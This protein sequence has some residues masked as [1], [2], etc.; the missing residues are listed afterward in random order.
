MDFYFL[1]NPFFL[2]SNKVKKRNYTNSIKQQKYYSLCVFCEQKIVKLK[3]DSLEEIA[4]N[5]TLFFK[6]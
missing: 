1:K 3:N 2:F 4:S 6:T 5:K